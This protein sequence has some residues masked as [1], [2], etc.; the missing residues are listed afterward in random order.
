MCERLANATQELISVHQRLYA[1]P[2]DTISYAYEPPGAI[3]IKPSYPRLNS[4]SNN[5]NNKHTNSSKSHSPSALSPAGSS[6]SGHQSPSLISPNRLEPIH[7]ASSAPVLST[8]LGGA[9]NPTTVYNSYKG[10]PTAATHPYMIPSP[11]ASAPA[12]LQLNQQFNNN[13]GTFSTAYSNWNRGNEIDFNSL[14]FL[15]DT[16]LFGQVVF[17]ANSP[18]TMNSY[19]PSLPLHSQPPQ[20]NS[21]FE[22]LLSQPFSAG[23]STPTSFTSTR[24]W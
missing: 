8:L 7:S 22:P 3:D 14:E 1:P 24:P 12:S 19:P 23:E 16:G 13:N 5:N 20:N 2:Q 18:I 6:S 17:D 9:S 15:Y 21:A 11:P 4:C 10:S